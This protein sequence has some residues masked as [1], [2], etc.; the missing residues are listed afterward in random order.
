MLSIAQCSGD[1]TTL[2]PQLLDHSVVARY[3]ISPLVNEPRL[4]ATGVEL[5]VVAPDLPRP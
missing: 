1:G 5:A 4:L 3:M 2:V